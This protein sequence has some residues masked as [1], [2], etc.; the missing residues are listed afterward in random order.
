MVHNTSHMHTIDAYNRQL[1]VP[2]AVHNLHTSKLVVPYK[3]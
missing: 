3:Y 2:I 1:A